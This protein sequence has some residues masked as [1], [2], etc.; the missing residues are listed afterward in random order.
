[1]INDFSISALED[2]ARK[3]ISAAGVADTIYS[4]RPKSGPKVES[5]AVARVSGSVADLGPYG[6]CVLQ[7]ELYARDAAE[8]K[9]GKRLDYMYQRL[10]SALPAELEGRYMLDSHPHVLSDEGDDFG[11]HARIVRFDTVI[12]IKQD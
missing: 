12:K 6:T 8:R 10:V 7:I 2:A 3:W 1:M 11:Y 9:N 5:F 4:A